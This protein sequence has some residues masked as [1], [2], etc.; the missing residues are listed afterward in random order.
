MKKIIIAL[1]MAM[2]VLTGCGGSDGGSSESASKATT[3]GQADNTLT[4]ALQTQTTTLDPENYSLQVEGEVASQ[5]YEPL[6]I[7]DND[8]NYVYILIDDMQVSEDYT[9][10]TFVL[11]D[12]VQFHSGDILEAEDVVYTLERCATSAVCGTLYLTSTAMAVDE[13]TVTFNFPYGY[14]FAD[15]YSLIECMGIVNKS[16]C[17]EMISDPTDNLYYNCDGTGAYYFDEIS[18]T[19]DITL[20]RFEDYHGE[21][22]IDTLYFHINTGDTSLAFESGDLDYVSMNGTKAAS[23]EKYDNV[24]FQTY[25]APNIG[26]ICVNSTEQSKLYDLSMRQAVV[27]AL[28]RED[29]ATVASAG[30]GDVA[31][32]MAYPTMPYYADCCDHF[33]RDVEKSKSLLE[34]AGYSESNPLEL[35]VIAPANA[36]GSYIAAAEVLKENLEESYFSVTIEEVSDTT[37]FMTQDYD[38]GIIAAG[39]PSPYAN[40][41]ML[42]NDA[43]NLAGIC[44]EQQEEV[45]AAFNNIS[46]EAT[47]QEAMRVSTESLAYIPC[48]YTAV[49]YVSDA[50]LNAGE[51]YMDPSIMFYREF[52]WK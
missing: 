42:Y 41:A 26:M 46:D 44:G 13:K 23:F 8:G 51:Y 31:Y 37:R 7:T 34:E 9:S 30:D 19:G 25:T 45:L 11:K 14:T 20:K 38:L 16:F 43:L 12:D 5:I 18:N 32:N 48:Y 15:L 28:N 33:D 47:T 10:V 49:H 1:L 21:A 36:S 35:T 3:S 22:S 50:N 4:L 27:Y 24:Q 39:L 29:V 52:S 17:E 6:F 40:Y 2:M